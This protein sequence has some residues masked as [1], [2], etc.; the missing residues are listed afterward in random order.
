MSAPSLCRATTS[1]AGVEVPR[2]RDGE[3]CAEEQPALEVPR[4]GDYERPVQE[5]PAP[6]VPRD[7]NDK[8]RAGN[9]EQRCRR[10]GNVDPQRKRS[11]EALVCHVTRGLGRQGQPHAQAQGARRTPGYYYKRI[12]G[13]RNYLRLL[14]KYSD[15][16]QNSNH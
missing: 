10:Q 13:M 8:Q 9:E 5:Q 1:S 14:R 4:N 12:S 11:V 2:D 6:E 3:Q 16:S 15:T 7:V